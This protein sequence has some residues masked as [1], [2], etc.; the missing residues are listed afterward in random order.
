LGMGPLKSVSINWVPICGVNTTLVVEQRSNPA[1]HSV[2]LL[3]FEEDKEEARLSPPGSL[4]SLPHIFA[5]PEDR[6]PA[7]RFLDKLLN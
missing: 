2:A 3:G 7:G 1:E 4:H 6:G 5:G